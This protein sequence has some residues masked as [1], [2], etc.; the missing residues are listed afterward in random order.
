MLKGERRKRSEAKPETETKLMDV[1]QFLKIYVFCVNNF[2][3]LDFLLARLFHPPPAYL[4]VFIRLALDRRFY[5]ENICIIIFSLNKLREISS[6]RVFR[7][8]Q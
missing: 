6:L 5:L 1:I 2:V 8:V 3:C 7:E 4:F